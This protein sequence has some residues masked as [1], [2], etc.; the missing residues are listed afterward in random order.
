M[1]VCLFNVYKYFVSIMKN[2]VKKLCKLYIICIVGCNGFKFE[3]F[4]IRK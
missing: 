4:F 2:I 3:F 1:F